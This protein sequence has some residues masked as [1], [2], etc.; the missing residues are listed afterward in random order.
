MPSSSAG[1]IWPA[2]MFTCSDGTISLGMAS[3]ASRAVRIATKASR[4]LPP[5]TWTFFAFCSPTVA[6]QA[7]SSRPG[8]L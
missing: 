1:G 4:D 2:R 7:Y 5:P 3:V 6:S 8:A